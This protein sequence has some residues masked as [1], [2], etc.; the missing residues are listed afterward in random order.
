MR[1]RDR[2][3]PAVLATRVQESILEAIWFAA[4][5]RRG[6]RNKASLTV[7]GMDGAHPSRFLGLSRKPIPGVAQKCAFPPGVGNPHHGG[8]VIR[9][10]AK[11]GLPLLR[12]FLHLTLLGD[13]ELNIHHADAIAAR[14]EQRICVVGDK[15]PRSVRALNRRFHAFKRTAFTQRTCHR[16][17]RRRKL[18]SL[19][20]EQAEGS[21]PL[22]LSTLRTTSPQPGGFLIVKEKVAIF[23]QCKAWHRQFAQNLL[24]QVFAGRKV[25]RRLE[26]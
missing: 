14:I 10:L 4:G 25:V 13:V 7:L 1:S 22:F 20:R 6:R 8:S 19:W 16:G 11:K 18:L 5:P 9:H 17:K 26:R 3:H 24:E 15:A 2:K 23:I 21:A 12:G